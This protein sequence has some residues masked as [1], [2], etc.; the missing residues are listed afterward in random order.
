MPSFKRPGDSDL[1]H[2][3]RLIVA[4]VERASDSLEVMIWLAEGPRTFEHL[5]SLRA[6]RVRDD[7]PE[8][9]GAMVGNEEAVA[10]GRALD[11]LVHDLKAL[12]TLVRHQAGHLLLREG[13]SIALD[14]LRPVLTTPRRFARK[15]LS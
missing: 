15:P 3:V 10:E 6:Q 1:G 14:V 9:L 4:A 2:N 13:T 12:G 7:M 5:L 8:F 11:T